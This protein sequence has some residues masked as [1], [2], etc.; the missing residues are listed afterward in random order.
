MNMRGT[1][2]LPLSISIADLSENVGSEIFL[3]TNA[4]PTIDLEMG[5]SGRLNNYIVAFYSH[6]QIKALV[7]DNGIREGD[8]WQKLKVN[9][10]MSII[11]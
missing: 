4:I 2:Y 10:I 6:S 9:S 5:Q 3:D 7:R 8:A 1:I 11:V